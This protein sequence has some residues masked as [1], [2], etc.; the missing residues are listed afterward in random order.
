[1]RKIFLLFGTLFLFTISLRAQNDSIP[2]NKEKIKKGWTL[3]A[4]PVVG[5]DADLGFQYGALANVF[6]YG[7][8]STYPEYKSSIYVE[9]SRYTRGSGV[10]QL[11]YDSKY[12]IPGHIRVTADF[13]YLT[14]KALPFYGFNGYEAAYHPGFEEQGG[15]DYISRVFYRHERKLLRIMADFQGPI[16]GQRFRWL[17]GINFFGYKVATVDINKLNKGK[18]EDKKLP[19]VPLLYDDYVKYGFISEKEKNGG[20]TIYIKLGFIYDT[21]DMEAA[22]NKGIWSE[23]L[24]LGAPA[25]IGNKDFHFAKL[26]VI[27]RQYFTPYTAETCFGISHWLPGN[28]FGEG[29]LLYTA[30]Y[31]QFIF[32]YHPPGW[33]GWG[34][35]PQG[36]SP[37]PGGGRW[38]SLW[39][40]G[41]SLDIPEEL[42]L[43]A[44]FLSGT[45][46]FCRCRTGST[47]HSFR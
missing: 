17:A 39:K 34:A 31:V 7:D 11:F 4:L 10:N 5:Y 37:Q 16:A 46:Y 3:A 44:E 20:N 32:S 28:Y 2:E 18:K 22:P 24:F 1:M 14:D 27:H 35:E 6:D 41:T 43:Q 23:I 45:D 13:T 19:D 9:W 40:P 21:R 33:F 47:G 12:L 38:G 25:F 36:N 8:G 42:S 29:T 15:D 26:A 30:L